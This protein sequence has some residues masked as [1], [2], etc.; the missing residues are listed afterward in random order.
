MPPA[1]HH[2]QRERRALPTLPGIEARTGH[3]S[4]GESSRREFRHDVELHGDAARSLVHVS[5]TR[6]RTRRSGGPVA[7]R[8]A[9]ARSDWSL[10]SKGTR[11]GSARAESS[12]SAATACKAWR[13]KPRS[14]CSK[15]RTARSPRSPN[16]PLGVTSWTEDVH[17]SGNARVRVRFERPIHPP[18]RSRSAGRTTCGGSSYARDCADDVER[19]T[20]RH[21]HPENRGACR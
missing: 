7:F 5:G 15:C 6:G 9:R 3:R 11:A 1:R 10:S 12:I 2:L 21:R 17:H 16:S 4:A 19:H 18:L 13:A 14:N 20:T 8:R